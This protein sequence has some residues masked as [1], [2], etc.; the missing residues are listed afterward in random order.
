MIRSKDHGDN[1]FGG[2]YREI[3]A[4]HRLVFTWKWDNGPSGEVET[5]VTIT[6]RE[7]GDGSTTM[8]FH[9]TPFISVE[10]RDSAHRRL[11]FALQQVGIYAEKLARETQ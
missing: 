5:L 9:Q 7:D 8:T 1:W 3:E 2:E 4:P 6:F 11:E 10:R